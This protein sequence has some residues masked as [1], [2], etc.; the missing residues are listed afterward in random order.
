MVDWT[1]EPLSMYRTGE[2]RNLLQWF[3]YMWEIK[4]KKKDSNT[5]AGFL[6]CVIGEMVVTLIEEEYWRGV[7][8]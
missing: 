6:T 1:E 7:I 4:K 2:I 3:D 8:F 5:I